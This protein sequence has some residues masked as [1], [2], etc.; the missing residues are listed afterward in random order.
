MRSQATLSRGDQVS[1]CYDGTDDQ[2]CTV[3]GRLE[4]FREDLSVVVIL[5]QSGGIYQRYFFR[6]PL[7]VLRLD[8]PCK[9]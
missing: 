2:D 8:G 3:A 6:N 4:S 9:S 5:K 7:Y 1:V